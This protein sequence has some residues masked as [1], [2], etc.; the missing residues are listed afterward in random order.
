MDYPNFYL[1]KLYP[2]QDKFLRFLDQINVE[3]FYL[4]GGTALSR[5]YFN[6]RYSDDLD[7]FSANEMKDFKAVV[8]GILEKGRK[9]GFFIEVETLGEHFLRCYLKEGNIDL[10]IDFVN[11]TT[12]RFG[13]NSRTDLFSCVDNQINILANKIGCIDR[14][15]VKD[16]ADLWVLSRNLDFNW[17]D[18]FAIADRKSPVDPLEASKIIQTLPQDELKLVKWVNMPDISKI[19]AQ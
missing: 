2:L 15:E 14:H 16:M 11:E 1:H 3:R 12:F 17:R 4:T 5:C 6:H 8:T 7:F 10:K 9:S 18:M 13:E 19:H